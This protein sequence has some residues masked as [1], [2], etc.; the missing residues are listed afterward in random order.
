V[1]IIFV[2]IRQ[3][4]PLSFTAL[5]DYEIHVHRQTIKMTIRQSDTHSLPLCVLYIS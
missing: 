5:I 3:F 2:L 4:R 1:A